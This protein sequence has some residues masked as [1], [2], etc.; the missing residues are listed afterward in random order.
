[1]PLRQQ[2]N[3]AVPVKPEGS[4]LSFAELLAIAEIDSQ[5]VSAALD[6]FSASVPP[7][8]RNLLD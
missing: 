5:D 7:R 1:M 3:D 2:R 6:R 4:P 8:Y